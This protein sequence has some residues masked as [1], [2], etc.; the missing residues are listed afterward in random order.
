M[1]Q[2]SN[3]RAPNLAGHASQPRLRAWN[4]EMLHHAEIVSSRCSILCFH[5]QEER[6]KF[7]NLNVCNCFFCQSPSLY[8]YMI[9]LLFLGITDTFV[10]LPRCKQESVHQPPFLLSFYCNSS[11]HLSHNTDK[12]VKHVRNHE[13]LVGPIAKR[14]QCYGAISECLEPRVVNNSPM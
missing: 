7:H 13:I 3:D 9:L 2:P 11:L 4:P 1:F 8:R 14:F 5:S 6:V 12:P 10:Q